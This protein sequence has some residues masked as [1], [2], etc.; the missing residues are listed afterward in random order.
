MSQPDRLRVTWVRPQP[1]CADK[2]K[3]STMLTNLDQCDD[4]RGPKNTFSNIT[5]TDIIITG[6]HPYST[7]DVFIRAINDE[8]GNGVETSGSGTTENK[9]RRM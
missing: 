9:G 8:A 1:P 3:V 4:T 6:L 7:Y 5:G 2:F